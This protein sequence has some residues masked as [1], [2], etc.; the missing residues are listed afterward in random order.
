MVRF[1][2]GILF[3]RKL[4]VAKVFHF[5]FVVYSVTKAFF[6]FPLYS[7]CATYKYELHYPSTVS[8]L[9]VDRTDFFLLQNPVIIIYHRSKI[10]NRHVTEEINCHDSAVSLP[11]IF[12]FQEDAL[13]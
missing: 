8:E 1:N 4:L 3:E 2:C 11:K 7:E 5:F 6:L 10:V 12:W 13:K 9:H